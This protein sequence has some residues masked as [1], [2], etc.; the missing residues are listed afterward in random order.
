MAPERQHPHSYSPPLRVERTQDPLGLSAIKW[1]TKNVTSQLLQPNF[2]KNEPLYVE[3]YYTLFSE[4]GIYSLNKDNSISRNDYANGYTFFAFDLI[5]DLSANC[6]GHWNL[7]K[8]GS[9]RLEV[10]FEEVL[11]VT[12]NCIIYA[13]FDNV[14]EIDF[15]RH[16]R[17]FWLTLWLPRENYFPLTTHFFLI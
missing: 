16:C 15:S 1:R 17:L 11:S 6:A 5:P 13:K 4:T 14:L 7:V 2:S 3:A 12:I 9:L 8:H 10:K